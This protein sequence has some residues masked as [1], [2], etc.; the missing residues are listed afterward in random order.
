MQVNPVKLSAANQKVWE[1]YLARVADEFVM[2]LEMPATTHAAIIN[3]A[4]ETGMREGEAW[5]VRG[6][7]YWFEVSADHEMVNPT[8]DSV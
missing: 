4:K 7:K 3:E 8:F 2:T 6:I 5:Y 1:Q